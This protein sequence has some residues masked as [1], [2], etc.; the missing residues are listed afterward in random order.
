MK[1]IVYLDNGTEY[2]VMFPSGINHN[3]MADAIDVLRFGGDHDWHRRQGEVVA[4]GFIDRLGSCSG[5]SET[6]GIKSR[7]Q[8]DT[9]LFS[10][11]GSRAVKMG[12]E[13]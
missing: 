3:H 2:G 13:K 12:E 6:L 11:G 7:G 10:Q 9:E 8:I 1:Y 5:Y 4:A